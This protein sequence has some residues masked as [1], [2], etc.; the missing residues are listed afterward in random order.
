MLSDVAGYLSPQHKL[1]Q[2]SGEVAPDESH[3]VV[4][5]CNAHTVRFSPVIQYR[6]FVPRMQCGNGEVDRSEEHTS[7]LQSR[8][9]LVCRLLLEKKN[10]KRDETARLKNLGFDTDTADDGLYR[11]WVELPPSGLPHCTRL[12]VQFAAV[13]MR[14]YLYFN[15]P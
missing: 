8:Q 13:S 15:A 5:R 14:S 12:F 11:Q 3:T 10:I 4:L 2:R 9:Y 7:E 6:H 1:S